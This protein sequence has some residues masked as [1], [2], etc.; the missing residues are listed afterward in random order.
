[1]ATAVAAAI[2]ALCL[3]ASPG[4]L[5]SAGADSDWKGEGP[6]SNLPNLPSKASSPR[7]LEV[8]PQKHDNRQ[9]DTVSFSWP[10]AAAAADRSPDRSSHRALRGKRRALPGAG[11]GST[12]RR[13][14]LV[15]QDLPLPPEKQVGIFTGVAGW[16]GFP[17]LEESTVM[18]L[19]IFKCAGSTTRWV[20]R[21][22]SG[23][24]W[25]LRGVVCVCFMDEFMCW[26]PVSRRETFVHV[27][28]VNFKELGNSFWY[29]I[30]AI[31]YITLARLDPVN[32]AEGIA[33]LRP[34]LVSLVF[35]FIWRTERSRLM[36]MSV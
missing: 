1:M 16:G 10:S 35:S 21:N 11:G 7:Q 4:C 12:D 6:S 15:D 25:M 31:C 33:R 22:P 20:G 34:T 18:F 2:F 30:E 27:A 9:Y 8:S 19:H 23:V 36:G 24:T 29:L 3:L 5:L 14:A 28:I 13:V 17:S 32:L 26:E